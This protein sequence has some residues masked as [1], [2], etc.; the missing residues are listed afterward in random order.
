VPSFAGAGRA[1][2][3]TMTSTSDDSG[4]SA[5]TDSQA[6]EPVRK[7]P[8]TVGFGRACRRTQ[9]ATITRAAAIFIVTRRGAR[10]R[11]A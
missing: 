11:L 5:W 3:A 6:A 4:S 10:R 7:A 1:A 9:S 8:R 2:T